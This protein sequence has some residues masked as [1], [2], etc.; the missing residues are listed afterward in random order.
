MAVKSDYNSL[1][2]E[3]GGECKIE[4]CSDIYKYELCDFNSIV[5]HHKC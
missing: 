3:N 5:D 2:T 4:I 1:T